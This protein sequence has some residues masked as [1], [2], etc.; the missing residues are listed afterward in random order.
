[1][2]NKLIEECYTRSLGLLRNN[3]C[4][5]GILASAP[6]KKA[7]QRNYLSVFSRDASICSLGMIA[8]GDKELV[9]SAKKSLETLGRHQAYNGQIPN[10]VKPADGR[11]DF[12]RLG[13]IDATLWWLIALKFYDDYT[14][15]TK[16]MER[17]QERVEAAIFW[18]LCQEHVEDGLVMQNEA[19]DWAD[20][21]PRSGKVLYSN[22]LWSHVKKIYKVRRARETRENFNKLFYPFGVKS[23]DVSK[24]DRTTV[25]EI[26]KGEKKDVYFGFVGYLYWGTAVNVYANS[27]AV[28]FGLPD[29]KLQNKIVD[30]LLNRRRKKS[31]PMPVLFDPIRQHSQLWRKYMESHN[32]NFP[33]QYH[34]GGVWPFA[35][36][37]WVIALAKAGR[38]EEA[39]I[40]LERIAEANKVNRW[41]FNEWFH[42]KTGEPSGMHWQSWNAGMFV[43][44]YH[45]LDGDFKF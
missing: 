33:Y 42:A 27:L 5:F 16:L 30:H 12:W 35:S 1:M 20:I 23:S 10:Y 17:M 22:V 4:E 25:M 36:C 19:S 13:C 3:S 37:F 41:Q 21:M 8:T 6:Q 31:L 15:D 32:Q 28:V 39:K 11:V 24:C 14:D 26:Q 43:A 29:D 44:A 18:L 34:N 40:E 38:I 9:R 45:Y 7:V 2:K